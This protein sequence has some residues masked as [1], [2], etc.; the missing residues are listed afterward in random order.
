MENKQHLLREITQEQEFK[1]ANIT[2]QTTFP[3]F[4]TIV[5]EAYSE[6]VINTL[7]K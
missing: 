4:K 5:Q 3:P 1:C 2:Y 6:K 7:C